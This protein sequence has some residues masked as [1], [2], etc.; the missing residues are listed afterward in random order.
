MPKENTSTQ[1]HVEYI[2]EVAT[3]SDVQLAAYSP[4][5][6]QVTLI[7]KNNFAHML[8]DCGQD[9]IIDNHL[10]WDLLFGHSPT[11]TEINNHYPKY[12]TTASSDKIIQHIIQFS[13]GI[14][15]QHLP[16]GFI[17]TKNPGSGVRDVLHYDEYYAELQAKDSNQDLAITLMTQEELRS[18]PI[19]SV[20]FTGDQAAWYAFLQSKR[21]A[22]D[23]I[24]CTE[25]Q[26]SNAFICFSNLIQRIGLEYNCP[27]FSDSLC[28]DTGNPIIL[29]GRWA[30][31]LS[32][33]RLKKLDILEQ[34][35]AI[36][37]LPLMQ[38][39]LAITAITYYALD[40]RSCGFVLPEMELDQTPEDDG[41][42]PV[43]EI[44]LDN[45]V[46]FWRYLAYQ[47]RCNSI[48][49]YKS[50]WREI[51]SI[52]S[53]L[54]ITTKTMMLQILVASTNQP[55]HSAKIN[56]QHALKAWHNVCQVV[57]FGPLGLI[58]RD[59]SDSVII[60]LH[61]LSAKPNLVFLDSIAKHIKDNIYSPGALLIL[62]DKL[63]LLVKNL[64][65]SLYHGSK[66]YFIE[67][68][69]KELSIKL[70]V[71]LQYE[72]YRRTGGTSDVDDP[73]YA[74][75]HINSSLQFTSLAANLSTF[76]LQN[77]QHIKD[78][79]SIWPEENIEQLAF[80][81][82]LFNEAESN[83][84]LTPQ[85]LSKLIQDISGSTY[86]ADSNWKSL[87]LDLLSKDFIQ[88]FAPG[89]FENKKQQIL[90]TSN[91]L[92]TWQIA[93]IEKCAFPPTESASLQRLENAMVKLN[94]GLEPEYLANINDQ[95][96]NLQSILTPED[97][98]LFISRLE[99]MQVQVATNYVAGAG[100]I[101]LLF[102][103]RKL[104]GFNQ[105]F[106]RN[107]IEQSSVN[108]LE[109]FIMFVENILPLIKSHELKMNKLILQETLATVVL[110]SA[111]DD[112]VHYQ[113]SV[114]Q[115]IFQLNHAV[116][117]HSHIEHYLLD[118]LNHMPDKNSPEYMHGV[119]NF[120][121]NIYDLTDILPAYV[122]YSLMAK[123]HVAP[124]SLIQLIA[125]VKQSS[126]QP[127]MMRFISCLIDNNLSIDGLEQLIPYFNQHQDKLEQFSQPPYVDIP[128][129]LEWSRLKNFTDQYTKFSLEPYGPRSSPD[130]FN[131]AKYR[132]QRNQFIGI[133]SNIFTDNIGD[134]IL[135][136]LIDNR[137]KTMSQLI[138]CFRQ[139]D[140]GA[141]QLICICVEVI[142][143]TA[144]QLSHEKPSKIISQSLNT[145]QIMALYAMLNHESNQLISQI[146][147]GEGKSRI[148]MIL[149]ACKAVQGQTVDFL[150]SDMQL[151]ERDYLS[152]KQFFTA[153]QIPT[154]LI[155]L[156][157]PAELYQKSGVNFT[158]NGQL[159]L[160]RNRCDI[161]LKADY[162]DPESQRRCL[163]VDEVDKFTHD[164]S[165]DSYNYAAPSKKLAGYVWIYP[166][167]VRFVER[168]KQDEGFDP[169]THLAD[170]IGYI[171]E[172]VVD[173]VHKS[174]LL[175]L[176]D[177]D[178]QQ[179]A[180]WLRSAHTAW[181]MEAD[182]D[183]ILSSKLYLLRDSQGNAR[184]SR[185]I[186]VLD[187]GRPV[188]GSSY[189]E[190]LHQCLCAKE[191]IALNDE[192][193]MIMPENLTRRASFPVNFMDNYKSGA[194]YGVSGTTRSAAPL[195]DF[196]YMTVPR[197]KPLIRDDKHV[198]LAKDEDQQ[199]S[200]ILRAI[201]HNNS[202]PVLLI[203][204]DDQQSARLYTALQAVIK[205]SNLQFVH[206]LTEK[207]AEIDAIQRAGTQ[208]IVTISTAGMM[209]R[210]VD[211]NADNLLVLAAYVPTESDEIQ[212]K[213]RTARVGKPGEY[214]MIPNM[215]DSEYPLNGRTYNVHNEVLKSQK[216]RQCTAVF[217][218]YVCS[219]YAGFLEGI[220]QG[221]L[222]ELK[223]CPVDQ[224]IQSLEA[225]GQFLGE[226][227][228]DW[229]LQ[230]ET[231]FNAV[232]DQ[233]QTQFS[234]I[235]NAFTTKWQSKAGLSP[236]ENP[237]DNNPVFF[238]PKKQPIK[239]QRDYDPGD[240][241][242]A[243]IY[244]TLFP[245]TWATLRG[246]R[247][248]FADYH[249]WREGRGLLF[250]DFMAVLNGER[251]LFANLY[252]TIARW[253][254]ELKEWL[255]AKEGSPVNPGC[256][257]VPV[258]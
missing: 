4:H 52:A 20:K 107:Y 47:S 68:N 251:D 19:Q 103:T 159:L 26:L 235:F 166:N 211:I 203:C 246:E 194:I 214:R 181:Y 48:D 158:D 202:R 33:P 130:S 236:V 163:L 222:S 189:S 43:G 32:N 84:G 6:S 128:R 244:S 55:D 56:E 213:G 27:E 59:Y 90:N 140:L 109:K 255:A 230:R 82:D 44:H 229:S 162:L 169:S 178:P 23:K 223:A 184:Y 151:A 95:L 53:S 61:R 191:N 232:N 131:I 156:N 200:F 242:Q 121:K 193:F 186:F 209:G 227:Q 58:N 73:N 173:I 145:T 10:R 114:K 237:V 70:Y 134:E 81:L 160:L 117:V 215:S 22:G 17:L 119:C 102:R 63:G 218:K 46:A 195:E 5:S 197:E 204:K 248:W 174:D 36:P 115:L 123:F 86:A 241:G 41:F 219:V 216:Q 60:S 105:I 13:S 101:N 100:L 179:I 7:D 155:S 147:T 69:W 226:M 83:A 243:R 1:I 205:P 14:D 38:S 94:H 157:T 220:T 104:D 57:A 254:A 72:L 153:L 65:N 258:T 9:A 64:K 152:Y 92:T 175:R 133:A 149:A 208:E 28:S 247:N 87:L 150:T 217:Q 180:T 124:R 79:L 12:L 257:L 34:W 108:L 187:N 67:Q 171:G 118:C 80:C 88:N 168:F 176:K 8:L 196:K 99:S 16:R 112:G 245:K 206:G 185:K 143:R 126:N 144:Y 161:E 2:T 183:Y 122:I 77:V 249:A 137:V 256:S 45:P 3:Y 199:I 97:F 49:F 106:V 221:F 18:A 91:G 210:G 24:F 177:S 98:T 116:T 238:K 192:S 50:A 21:I 29:L 141:L 135:K 39:Y 54:N 51:D 93:N 30:T 212:I 224:Q 75:D 62:N 233:N 35:R 71:E 164:K 74:V 138:E 25:S 139:P 201:R 250:P 127:L 76:Q 182:K 142:A 66:F 252:A 96:L 165:Q 15:F 239:V 253:L 148:M 170:F 167:L 125:Q 110:N 113:E 225:W 31:V 198:W 190:G 89:Y 111:W 78:V 234:E 207:A 240:D 132:L 129:S 228:K 37:Q 231:L 136:E 154:S 11:Y 146:D 188:D 172:S 40:Q 120:V 85:R 42:R